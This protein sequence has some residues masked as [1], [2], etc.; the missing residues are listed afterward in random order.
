MKKNSVLSTLPMLMYSKQN[1]FAF[2]VEKLKYYACKEINIEVEF[3]WIQTCNTSILELFWSQKCN[4]RNCRGS[5]IE[6]TTKEVQSINIAR[7]KVNWVAQLCYL[8]GWIANLVATTLTFLINGDARLLIFG[9]FSTLDTLIRASPFINFWEK[10][11]PP[12][13]L[14][15]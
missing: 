13:L 6:F 14:G 12:L 11:H 2:Q 9:F 4:F 10:F 1:F 7:I 15:S 5:Y 3:E 8:A